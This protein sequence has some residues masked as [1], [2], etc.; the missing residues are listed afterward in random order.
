[1]PSKLV[2]AVLQRLVEQAALIGV[3]DVAG[4]VLFQNIGHVFRQP[5]AN[6]S[7]VHAARFT[8]EHFPN[9]AVPFFEARQ[10]ART[11]L[12]LVVTHQACER[13]SF[14][15]EQI[16]THWDIFCPQIHEPCEDGLFHLAMGSGLQRFFA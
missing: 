11:C 15:L 3:V 4:G 12:E 13:E 10:P 14:S 7:R 2:A 16:S 1:M 8:A 9:D 5:V 6:Y